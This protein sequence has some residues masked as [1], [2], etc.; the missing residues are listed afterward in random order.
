MSTKPAANSTVKVVL[1][2]R[3]FIV[4]SAGPTIREKPTIAMTLPSILTEILTI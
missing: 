1:S 3:P 4:S 2:S